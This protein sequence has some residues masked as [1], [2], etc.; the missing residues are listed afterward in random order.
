MKGKPGSVSLS[1]SSTEALE[2]A[3]RG[4]RFGWIVG[5]DE[6]G[7][8]LVDFEDNPAGPLSARSLVPLGRRELADAIAQRQGAYLSFEEDDLSRPVL[9]GLSQPISAS[10]L[11]DAFLDGRDE[12]GREARVDGKRVVLEGQ[13]EVVLKCGEATITLRR[14]GKV[15][16]RGLQVETHAAGTNRIKGASVKVN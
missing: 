7:W 11:L 3:R 13:E 12:P 4:P 16:I 15:L 1:E 5:A 8:L 14:N 10:P 9:I 6:R 2:P